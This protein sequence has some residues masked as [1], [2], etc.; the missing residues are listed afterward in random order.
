LANLTLLYV[1]SCKLV[2]LPASIMRLRK[3]EKL[4][5]SQNQI[6]S[7]PDSL[8]QWILSISPNA[9]NAEN[10]SECSATG[11]GKGKTGN[12]KIAPAKPPRKHLSVPG[13]AVDP[14]MKELNTGDSYNPLGRRL[15]TDRPADPGK[16][17]AAPAK[18][19]AG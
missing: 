9:L 12:G 5:F 1:S 3:L 14:G 2:S 8:R 17:K 4:D 10:L 18:G 16:G 6:C 13:A 11:I 7:V 15:G 19:A